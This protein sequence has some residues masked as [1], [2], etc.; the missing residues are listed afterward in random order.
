MP[1]SSV[2]NGNWSKHE[3]QRFTHA[4]V[5]LICAYAPVEVARLL[6]DFNGG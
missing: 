5:S 4:P 3:T 6:V 1:Y 2:Y